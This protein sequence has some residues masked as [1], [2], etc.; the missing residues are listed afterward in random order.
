MPHKKQGRRMLLILM[1]ALYNVLVIV[2]MCEVW[3]IWNILFTQ[4][5]MRHS[6]C[7]DPIPPGSPGKME[8]CFD[9]EKCEW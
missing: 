8:K 9:K 4:I 1:D 2:I 3:I 7:S 6:N 5:V